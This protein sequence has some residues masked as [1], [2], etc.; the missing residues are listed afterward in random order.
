MW[1]SAKELTHSRSLRLF[2]AAKRVQIKW[3]NKFSFSHLIIQLFG[4]HMA[5]MQFLRCMENCMAHCTQNLRPTIN[6]IHSHADDIK[7]ENRARIHIS[8]PNCVTLKSKLTRDCGSKC[9]LHPSHIWRS[10]V[11]FVCVRACSSYQM[12]TPLFVMQ[13]NGAKFLAH[14]LQCIRVFTN[15]SLHGGTSSKEKFSLRWFTC[16]F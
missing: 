4:R 6:I 2:D 16:P 8:I 1:R 14:S 5:S 3:Q 7:G 13:N 12:E 15:H 10:N 11:W 9:Y